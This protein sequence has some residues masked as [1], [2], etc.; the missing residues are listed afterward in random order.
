[1]DGRIWTADDVAQLT[2]A[3]Q[4]ELFDASITDQL[5]G[6]PADFLTRVR[7]RAQARIKDDETRHA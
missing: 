2:P 7:D 4:D 6:V 5:D 3:Q 1:M